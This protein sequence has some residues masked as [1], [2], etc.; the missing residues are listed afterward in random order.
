[1]AYLTATPTPTTSL[2]YTA[3]RGPSARI[4]TATYGSRPQILGRPESEH[5]HV[6]VCRTERKE[7]FPRVKLQVRH[8]AIPVVL[9]EYRTKDWFENATRVPVALLYQFGIQTA[10]NCNLVLV[11]LA[12]VGCNRL[13]NWMTRCKNVDVKV[14][15]CHITSV[16]G[17]RVQ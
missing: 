1:M 14:T 5:A 2:W 6:V 10:G 15:F 8:V 11:A 17:T 9:P 4:R 3:Y 12:P 13:E 7:S 16:R